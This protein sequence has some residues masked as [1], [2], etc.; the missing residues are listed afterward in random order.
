VLPHRDRPDLLAGAAGG[1]AFTRR[2][3]I[4]RLDM[5]DIEP[6]LQEL[7]SRLQDL[8]GD[9]LKGLYLFGSYARG[10][11]RE[12][13]DIDVAMVLDDFERS[14]PEIEYS[15]DVVAD[16]DLKFECLIAAMP[17]RERDLREGREMYLRNIKREGVAI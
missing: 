17:V 6:I 9:R 3:G 8:Y 7:K 12:D 5:R 13:S 10:D 15:G 2:Q 16:L 14:L 11:A 4:M 1:L